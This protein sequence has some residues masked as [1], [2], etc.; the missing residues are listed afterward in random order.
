MLMTN[1]CPAAVI[2]PLSSAL[3]PARVIDHDMLTRVVRKAKT[4]PV[5][6]ATNC[7]TSIVLV[8]LIFL[9]SLM[10]G[11]WK[12]TGLAVLHLADGRDLWLAGVGVQLAHFAAQ[13]RKAW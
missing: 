3:H 8:S 4:R 10:C 6:A 12:L 9:F 5:G 2:G 11:T 1:T 13:G 7:L